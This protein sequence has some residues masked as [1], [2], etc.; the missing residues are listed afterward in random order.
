MN[1]TLG[2]FQYPDVLGP[3][4]GVKVRPMSIS[5]MQSLLHLTFKLTHDGTQQIWN[6]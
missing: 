1:W 6:A 2:I 4:I 3:A 5:Q